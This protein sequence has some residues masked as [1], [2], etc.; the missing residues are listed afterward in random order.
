MPNKNESNSKCRKNRLLTKSIAGALNKDVNILVGHHLQLARRQQHCALL[1]GGIEARDDD[2]KRR[3]SVR[4]PDDASARL[5]A[6]AR[7]K[8]VE[9]R[10]EAGARRVAD[11]SIVQADVAKICAAELQTRWRRTDKTF[12]LAPPRLASPASPRQNSCRRECA[13][14]MS[15]TMCT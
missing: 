15:S 7:S 13:R 6:S 11:E 2:C 3:P 10:L 4:P 1:R 12:C 9:H 14:R 8:R 5:T